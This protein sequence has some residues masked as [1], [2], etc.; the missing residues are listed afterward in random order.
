ML[1][2][3]L[4]PLAAAPDGWVDCLYFLHHPFQNTAGGL[5][6]LANLE[7]TTCLCLNTSII[8]FKSGSSDFVV[9]Q[10]TVPFHPAES[11]LCHLNPL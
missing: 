10:A 3:L 6:A 11:P 1:L 5:D 2:R 4:Q 8:P 9:S 7:N